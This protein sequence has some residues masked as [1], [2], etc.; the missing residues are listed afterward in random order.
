M[1]Q[2]KATIIFGALLL[3][4]FD[5]IADFTPSNRGCTSAAGCYE[6][7]GEITQSDALAVRS[8]AANI[9]KKNIS[10]PT[11]FL[12]SRGGDVYAA[13]SIGRDLRKIRAVAVMVHGSTCFSS[14][15]F[16]LAGATQRLVGGKVGVHRPY[17]EQTGAINAGDAQ[18]RYTALMQ[19]SKNFLKEMNIPGELYEAM[20][21]IPPEKI[22]ILNDF[23]LANFG[24]NRIDPVEEDLFD[25]LAAKRYGITKREYLRRKAQKEVECDAIIQTGNAE[26]YRACGDRVMRAGK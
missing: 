15:V 18:R 7:S 8:I 11:M 5:A 22:H 4:S 21:R 12:N 14:C 10:H 16:V 26:A 13:M 9:Q 20:V 25:S 17:S 23:D 24:L 2:I 1:S 6:L 19:D 3:F